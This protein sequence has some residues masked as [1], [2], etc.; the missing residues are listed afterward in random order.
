MRKRN[1]SAGKMSNVSKQEKHFS[2]RK[3]LSTGEKF[4][5]QLKVYQMESV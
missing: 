3:N 4:L 5:N 1:F 2:A